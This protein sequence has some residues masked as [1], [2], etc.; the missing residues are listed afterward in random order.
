VAITSLIEVE[1][2]ADVAEWVEEFDVTGRVGWDTD[3][4]VW[5]TYHVESGRP[6]YAVIDQDFVLLEV[7]RDHDL[8]EDVALDALGL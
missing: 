7:T 8:A 3:R 1:S 2:T 4:S 5:K 6:Q